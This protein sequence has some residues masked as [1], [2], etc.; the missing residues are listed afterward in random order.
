MYLCDD[1]QS[2]AIKL[3]DEEAEAYR[4]LKQRGIYVCDIFKR[5]LDDAYKKQMLA[6]LVPE[7]LELVRS[8][9]EGEG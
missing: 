6:E 3:D 7:L 4:H 2:I 1:C 9:K 8:L 5:V